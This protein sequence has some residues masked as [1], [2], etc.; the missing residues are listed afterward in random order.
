MEAAAL[1]LKK[2]DKV[3]ALELLGK[4]IGMFRDRVETDVYGGV[5]QTWQK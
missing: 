5:V 3:K 1:R 4:H 2:H